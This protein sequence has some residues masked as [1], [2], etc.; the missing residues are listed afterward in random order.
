M[1]GT[2]MRW[3]EKLGRERGRTRSGVKLGEQ[4]CDSAGHTY[5]EERGSE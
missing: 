1:A 4:Q 5:V 3:Q 2:K